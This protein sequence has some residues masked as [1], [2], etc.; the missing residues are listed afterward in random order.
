MN[1]N[2]AL[3]VRVVTLIEGPGAFFLGVGTWFYFD[4]HGM[5]VVGA[6]LGTVVWTLVTD[7][8][9]FVAVNL[10]WGNALFKGYPFNLRKP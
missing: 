2:E 10:G 8:E 6:I 1:P 3:R 4:R 5:P 7:L 9:H